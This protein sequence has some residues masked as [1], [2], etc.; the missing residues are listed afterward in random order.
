MW[1]IYGMK[2]ICLTLGGPEKGSFA[3]VTTNL[4]K[5]AESIVGKQLLKGR[6]ELKLTFTS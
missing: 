5:S 4:R 2:E 6:I 1:Q 3:S